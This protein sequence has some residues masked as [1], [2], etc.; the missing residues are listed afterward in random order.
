M[1]ALSNIFW[2][3]CHSVGQHRFSATG[4]ELSRRH[5]L[6]LRS[7]QGSSLPLSA[8]RRR[9]ACDKSSDQPRAADCSGRVQ[10]GE[11]GRKSGSGIGTAGQ[12]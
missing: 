12:G 11:P 1:K 8:R 10:A 9:G 4:S 2:H 7:L 5:L 3:R 6:L